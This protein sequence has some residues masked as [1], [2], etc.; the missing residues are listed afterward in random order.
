MTEQLLRYFNRHFHADV[1]RNE[2]D[3]QAAY[4]LRYQV[5]CDERQYEDSQRFPD[6]QETDRYDVRSVQMLVRHRAGG[7]PLGVVRLILP[8]WSAPGWPFPFQEVCSR[9]LGEPGA[10]R[11]RPLYQN[12]AEVS[13]FA[14]S[15]TAVDAAENSFAQRI[16]DAAVGEEGRNRSQFSRSVALGLIGLLFAASAEHGIDYWYA[17]ME[18]SLSRHLARL[19]IDFRPIGPAV[20][21]RGLRVPMMVRVDDALANIAATNP[22][23]YELI[24]FVRDSLAAQ[25]PVPVD[26]PEPAFGFAEAGRRWVDD[27]GGQSSQWDGD[28]DVVAW[29]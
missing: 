12:A 10:G 9:G 3:R 17:M 11:C 2:S 21:H 28:R 5:Y 4:Q 24:R 23:F 29:A 14:V 26:A 7:T 1:A 19:G 16:W 6:G 20:E 13:R 15:R 18:S 27:L 22:A 25:V 8:D